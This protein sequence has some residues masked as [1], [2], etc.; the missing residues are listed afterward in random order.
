L[1]STQGL[2]HI[3]FT[4]RIVDKKKLISL[5]TYNK[6]RAE[7]LA[8]VR[9]TIDKK[10]PN[11]IACPKCGM[12]LYDSSPLT[13]LTSNPPRLQVECYECD[14]SGARVY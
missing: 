14:F 11:G 3:V 1:R 2:I 7:Q 10:F 4:R 9:A 6:E 12:E 8:C 5:E 13:V